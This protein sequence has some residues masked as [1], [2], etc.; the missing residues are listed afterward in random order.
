MAEGEP[1]A[2]LWMGTHPSGPS[3]VRASGE[4]LLDHVRRHPGELGERVAE[5]FGGDL[6]FL[7]K[8]LSVRTAL[9]I[10]AHPDKVLAESLH[11]ERPGVYK[12]ANHKP[13]MALALTDFEA[14]SGF[15]E[16]EALA[17]ALEETPELRACVGD[18]AEAVAAR[19]RGGGMEQ[20]GRC[21]RPSGG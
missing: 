15:V 2:E 3:V 21:E 11:A 16:S 12:D 17:R 7:F 13:E 5:R 9:S 8:V 14:L 4:P 10:Q 18:G 6:P 20:P 19:L 1:Y